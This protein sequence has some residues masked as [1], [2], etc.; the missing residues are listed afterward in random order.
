MH[1]IRIKLNKNVFLS[2]PATSAIWLGLL[3]FLMMVAQLKDL[4]LKDNFFLDATTIATF[5]RWGAEFTIGSSY[6][7]TSAF[8]DTIG[9]SDNSPLFSL[10]SSLII[11]FSFYIYLKKASAKYIYFGEFSLLV[12]LTF[13][14]TVF[15]TMLSKELLVVLVIVPFIYFAEKGT[16]GLLIWSLLAIVY[17]TYFR[18]YWFLFIAEFW[19]LYLV[20]RSTRSALLLATVVPLS[21]FALS[22]FFGVS[23]GIDLDSF[24]TKVNDIRLE[25]NVDDA[26]TMIMPWL[27]GGGLIKGWLNVCITWITLMV[28][29]PLI[30][31]GT[32]YYLIISYAVI[33]MYYKIWRRVT[34]EIKQKNSEVV[35]ACAALV[36]AYVTIQSL[37]EPDYGSYVRHLSPFYPLIFFIII[38]RPHSRTSHT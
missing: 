13:L 12:F 9:I 8:Y 6:Q 20:F 33:V 4:F 24:R 37:F 2:R 18:T 23:L 22:V 16:I 26:R 11:I 31:M 38:S 32:P 19:L 35:S 15:M 3:I 34:I 14:S 5:I 27:P 36:L 1:I 29:L 7:S 28:P 10:S 25:G 21:L 17:A 30:L